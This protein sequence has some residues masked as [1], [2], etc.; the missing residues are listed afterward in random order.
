M[1]L[2]TSKAFIIIIIFLN[3]LGTITWIAYFDFLELIILA[4][5]H[6]KYISH[7]FEKIKFLKKIYDTNMPPFPTTLYW[8]RHPCLRTAVLTGLNRKQLIVDSDKV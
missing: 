7:N 6:C 2:S 1:I 8:I 5:R 3:V 4:I